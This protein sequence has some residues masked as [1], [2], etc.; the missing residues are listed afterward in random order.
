MFFALKNL[1]LAEYDAD[2]GTL[3]FPYFTDEQDPSPASRRKVW[4]GIRESL[5]LTRSEVRWYAQRV[6]SC[7]GKKKPP[8]Q[9]GLSFF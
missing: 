7:S 6:L 5:F 8:S 4:T 1:Y 3:S 2:T 9:R